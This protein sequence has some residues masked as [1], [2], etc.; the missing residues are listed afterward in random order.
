MNF[1][2]CQKF[3]VFVF[4]VRLTDEMRLELFPAGVIVRDPQH[5]KSPTRREHDLSLRRI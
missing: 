3:I 5:C 1:S 4:V 2:Y